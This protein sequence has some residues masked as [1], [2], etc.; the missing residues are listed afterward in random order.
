MTVLCYLEMGIETARQHEEVHGQ[1]YKLNGSTF[2]F[3]NTF[4]ENIKI[5]LMVLY[6]MVLMILY[7]MV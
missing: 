3:M 4:L 2:T 6:L 5:F 7:L 1:R